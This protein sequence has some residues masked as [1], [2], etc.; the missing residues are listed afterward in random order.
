MNTLRNIATAMGIAEPKHAEPKHNPRTQTHPLRPPPHLGTTES[1]FF[2]LSCQTI[3]RVLRKD[4]TLLQLLSTRRKDSSLQILL[5][6]DLTNRS[7]LI[8]EY[9]P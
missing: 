9:T 7:F 3:Q 4:K 2:T 8:I 5:P 1:T 6:N